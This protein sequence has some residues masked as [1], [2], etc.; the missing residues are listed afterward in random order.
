MRDPETAQGSVL[1][2]QLPENNATLRSFGHV[3]VVRLKRRSRKHPELLLFKGGPASRESMA[4]SVLITITANG[5][6]PT[7][8]MDKENGRV[9]LFYPSLEHPDVVALTQDPGHHMCYLWTSSTGDK[10]HAWLLKT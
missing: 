6:L 5:E 8:W 10:S 1:R 3:E 9:H 2:D 4:K 7:P